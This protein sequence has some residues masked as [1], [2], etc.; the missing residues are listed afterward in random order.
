MK[1][2]KKIDE[3]SYGVRSLRAAESW[4][5]AEISTIKAIQEKY[6]F[7]NFDLP[8]NLYEKMNAIAGI[9]QIIKCNPS[10]NEQIAYIDEILQTA[11]WLAELISSG[12][13]GAKIRKRLVGG[14]SNGVT[15]LDGDTF[16][17]QII[18]SCHQSKMK[19]EH[20]RLNKS[21]ERPARGLPKNSDTDKIKSLIKPLL[22]CLCEVFEA[23]SLLK[24]THGMDAYSESYDYKGNLYHFIIETFPLLK[25]RLGIKG[26]TPQVIGRYLTEVRPKK[27]E[28]FD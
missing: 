5:E 12:K 17:N 23:G 7:K 4:S 13:M 24:P 15:I 19:I 11:D 20:E 10:E 18:W 22:A 16:L 1:R 6:E 14:L 27:F 3:I 21:G 28:K 2:A 8:A 9:H 26:G 25:E